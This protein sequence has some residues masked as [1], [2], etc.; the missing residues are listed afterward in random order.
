MLKKSLPILLLVLFLI[1]ATVYAQQPQYSQEK[2]AEMKQELDQREQALQKTWESLQ[3]EH[4]ELNRLA[5]GGTLRGSRK[6][7]FMRRQTAWND[8]MMEYIQSR[9]K[10]HED[11]EAYQSAVREVQSATQS[12]TNR[13]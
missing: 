1:P 11:M 13:K 5:S 9:K 7:R 10:L 6:N 8:G 2:L 4:A 12:E 3:K